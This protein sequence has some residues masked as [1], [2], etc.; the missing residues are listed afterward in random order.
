MYYTMYKLPPSVTTAILFL[1]VI[2]IFRCLCSKSTY[3]LSPF[4]IMVDTESTGS[5]FDLPNKMECVPGP[6]KEASYYTTG[7]TP[8]GVCGAQKLVD[9][10]A[11]Y[12]ITSGV[13]E[14]LMDQ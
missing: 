2:I 1:S 4:P 11:S 10:Q 13:G 6:S 12:T 3:T 7:L 8:G 5:L 14:S 9:A